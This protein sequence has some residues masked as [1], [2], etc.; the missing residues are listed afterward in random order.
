MQFTTHSPEQLLTDPLRE[1]CETKLQRPIHRH[2]FDDP[3]VSMN[4]DVSQ[5]GESVELKVRV[6]L[7][8]MSPFTVTGEHEDP[9]AAIDLTSDKLERRMRDIADK[10]RS[11]RRRAGGN[12]LPDLG[13][14]DHDIFTEEEEQQLREM[15][16]LDAV[17]ET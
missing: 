15:G 5:H 6:T 8:G 7:P 1:Y 16:A 3:A 9:Y 11:Q 10:R 2:K 13:D 17:L 14:E 4:V 12:N